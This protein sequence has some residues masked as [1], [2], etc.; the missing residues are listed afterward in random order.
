MEIRIKKIY[1][2]LYEAPRSKEYFAKLFDVSTKTIENTI[3]N[4]K[5]DITYDK[6]LSSYRFINLLPKYISHESFFKLFQSSIGNNVIKNDFIDI[7]KTIN[8][9]EADFPMINTSTLSDLAQKIILCDIAIK[10]NCILKINYTGNSKSREIKYI[11]PHTIIS[12]GF[13]YYLYC[14]YDEINKKDIGEFRS[15]GFNGMAEVMPYEYIKDVK[16]RIEQ[17]GNAYGLYERDRFVTLKL[18]P[19]CAS[20]FKRE[21]LLQKENFDFLV[22]DQD[23]SIHINMYYNNIQEIISLLQQWMPQIS[24]QKNLDL[25][26]EIYSKIQSNFE[27]LIQ[28]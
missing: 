9:A 22:E 25:K 21:G 16:F 4:C 14:S 11:R 3:N 26:K 27:K 1:H 28:S 6:K 15:L 7:G 10:H 5:N 18:M 19:Y 13:T 20:F 12:T 2:E 24:I 23:G 8:Q 17:T